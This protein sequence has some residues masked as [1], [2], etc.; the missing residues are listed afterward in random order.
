MRGD[1]DHG[2]GYDGDSVLFVEGWDDLDP[3]RHDVEDRPGR[4]GPM[5]DTLSPSKFRFWIDCNDCGRRLQASSEGMLRLKMRQ[6]V[7]GQ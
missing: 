5:H 6:H 4:W 1:H 7:G 3:G 2:P